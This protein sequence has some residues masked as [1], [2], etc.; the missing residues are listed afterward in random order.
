[1]SEAT[2]QQFAEWA[3]VEIMGHKRFAGYVTESEFGGAVMIRVDV[4]HVT[5]DT[6]HP[7]PAFSKL[8]GVSAIYCISPC[9]EETARAFAA[10]MRQESFARYEAP[11]LTAATR[12]DFDAD[13]D[14]IEDDDYD[15]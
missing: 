12:P 4:P 10:S 6:G 7:L 14:E 11:R 15:E 2:R 3:I 8:F 1:M 9:T 5:S 13:E